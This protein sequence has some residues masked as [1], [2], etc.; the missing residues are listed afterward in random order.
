MKVK[1]SNSSFHFAFV[2][3]DSNIPLSEAILYYTHIHVKFFII[4]SNNITSKTIALS[5][6]ITLYIQ[7]LLS[8]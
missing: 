6:W 2:Y 3:V 4:M 8:A 7:F 5:S 1:V